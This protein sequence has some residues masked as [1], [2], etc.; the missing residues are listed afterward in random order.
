MICLLLALA[1]ART[2]R[3]CGWLSHQAAKFLSDVIEHFGRPTEPVSMR[4]PPGA[5][6]EQV[7]VHTDQ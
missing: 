6:A 1:A 4:E 7:V 2:A 5:T 3:H